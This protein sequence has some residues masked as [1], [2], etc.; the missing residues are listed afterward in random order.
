[1]MRANVRPTLAP[2][3]MHRYFLV[4][5][6][7][8]LAACVPQR[9]TDVTPL[10]APGPVQAPL[11]PPPPVQAAPEGWHLLD[12]TTDGIA[13][14]GAERAYRELL[15]GREPR[16]T[17]VIAVIDGG[18]D[19]AHADLRAN[20]W[21]NP[22][23]TPGNG[24]DDDDNGYVDDVHG[25][26]FI[27]GPDGRSV[28]YDT[29]EVTRLHV[30][31]TDRLRSG[32]LPAAERERCAAISRDFEEKRA[33]AMETA[34]QVRNIGDAL[35]GAVRVLQRALRTDSV[36]EAAVRALRPGSGEVQ[37]A[38][39]LYLQ[40]VANG[41]TPEVVA[42]ARKDIVAQV[43]YGYNTSFNPRAIVGDDTTD[44][45]QRRYG[46]RDVM[47]PDAMHGTHVGGISGAIRNNGIGAD[48]VAKGV[49]IMSV[50]AVPNGDERDKDVANAIRYAVDNGAHIINMS[51]GKA[52]SPQKHLVDEAVKYADARGVLMIRAAGNDGGDVGQTPSYPVATYDGGGRA[53][54]WIEVGASSWKG[55]DSLVALFSNYG[56]REVDVFAPGE[57]IHSTV[58]GNAYRS[59]SGT[60]MAAPVVSGL[61][62]MLM[63]YYPA[64]TAADVKR[65]ILQTA[66]R[67]PDVQVV[68]PGR[69][70]V[71]AHF[72][73]LSATGGIVDAVGAVQM[74]ERMAG[75]TP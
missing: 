29:Y 69:P 35:D 55:G 52:Y 19:T 56:Q 24:R 26:N 30:Q 71:K 7:S 3:V 58:P 33:S 57:D 36:T 62:A 17:V 54:N 23:E 28:N 75:A 31:C 8:L 9:T 25:W 41:I 6:A 1:M 68:V 2:S 72:G 50:R 22:R 73:T 5:L 4:G 40:L 61:A 59:V 53:Q 43:E 67:Y 11:P 49:R 27:G 15:A 39:Q 47:G 63:A 14:I 34:A 16:R 48:G 38:Q 65:I 64:L 46:N 42:D 10:P 21:V 44:L 32:T 66:R 20:L 74:A 37:H 13:G 70:G 60:S 45:T 12:V 18:V 51:F